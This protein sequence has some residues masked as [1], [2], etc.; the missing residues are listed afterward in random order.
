MD[1]KKSKQESIKVLQDIDKLLQEDVKPVKIP[2]IIPPRKT[3]SRVYLAPNRIGPGS[4]A[5]EK[6]DRWTKRSQPHVFIAP[7]SAQAKEQTGIVREAAKYETDVDPDVLKKR[8]P[9]PIVYRPRKGISMA[10]RLLR[11][12]K[13]RQKSIGYHSVSHKLV[14]RRVSGVPTFHRSKIDRKRREIRAILKYR[15]P[16]RK[17]QTWVKPQRHRVK[18]VFQYQPLGSPKPCRWDR[19]KWYDG[20]VHREWDFEQTPAVVMDR[21]VGREKTKVV[22]KAKMTIPFD[23]IPEK[24]TLLGPGRYDAI[25]HD[26]FDHLIPS[27]ARAF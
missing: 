20:Q 10:I 16:D 2:K 7:C 8:I 6:A 14:E 15:H 3:K 21:Q 4:Y 19:S 18:S 22:K 26:T 27:K 25:H 17:T 13:R 23:K 1:I 11:L 12:E 24:D 9:T 5:I